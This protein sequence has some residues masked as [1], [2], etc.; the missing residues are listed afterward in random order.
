MEILGKTKH[1]FHK[2]LGIKNFLS[3]HQPLE[4]HLI[5]PQFLTPLAWETFTTTKSES[6]T[7]TPVREVNQWKEQLPVFLS[8]EITIDPTTNHPHYPPSTTSKNPHQTIGSN[9]TFV[10]EN[11]LSYSIESPLVQKKS[12]QIEE[13]AREIYTN[14]KHWL[15]IERE[16]AGN[17]YFR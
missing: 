3:S 4:Q 8:P 16:R 6:I 1:N 13:L 15:Q 17:R 2:P 5:S 7:L 11:P 9:P 10:P 14:I 12:L